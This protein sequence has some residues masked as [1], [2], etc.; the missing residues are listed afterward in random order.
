MI[1]DDVFTVF[2]ENGEEEEAFEYRWGETEN[3]QYRLERATRRIGTLETPP[4]NKTLNYNDLDRVFLLVSERGSGFK[5]F[6]KWLE[7]GACREEASPGERG[8]TETGP[9]KQSFQNMVSPPWMVIDGNLVLHQ[10]DANP[11]RFWQGFLSGE[12]GNFI[13]DRTFH[14]DSQTSPAANLALAQINGVVEAMRHSPKFRFIH[15][16]YHLPSMEIDPVFSHLLDQC[17]LYRLPQF[18]IDELVTW[19]AQLAAKYKHRSIGIHLEAEEKEHLARQIKFRVGGQPRLTSALFRL[20]DDAILTQLPE[21]ERKP[22]KKAPPPPQSHTP[23][24]FNTLRQLFHV[25]GQELERNPPHIVERWKEDLMGFLRKDN[26]VVQLLRRYA[27]D[28]PKPKT[29]SHYPAD[30]QLYLAGWAGLDP[31][32]KWG[33]RSQCHKQWA[34]E[35]LRKFDQDK[36]RG[37]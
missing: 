27:D 36:E 17:H 19:L 8:E 26:H 1:R 21:E 29:D 13:L 24:G 2:K 22:P 20:V 28:K 31:D 25:M 32:G 7:N 14:G 11:P 37:R 5:V 4:E 23:L 15:A 30:T 33:I 3:S 18:E 10:S 9:A 16:S 35:L 12:P 6:R 34:G